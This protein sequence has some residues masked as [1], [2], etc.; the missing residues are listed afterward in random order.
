MDDTKAS[1]MIVCE[2]QYILL[3]H[4][5]Y[6]MQ[7]FNNWRPQFEINDNFSTNLEKMPSLPNPFM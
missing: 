4:E 6:S 1:Y 5:P 3:F 2:L 7:L